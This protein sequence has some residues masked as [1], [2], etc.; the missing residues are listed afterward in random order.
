[1]P[2]AKKEEF[3]DRPPIVGVG[4]IVRAVIIA[5]ILSVGSTMVLASR[6]DERVQ[7]NRDSATMSL[8]SAVE[9]RKA[10]QALLIQKDSEMEKSLLLMQTAQKEVIAIMSGLAKDNASFREE[11][12]R[13]L[14]T[15]DTQMGY[16]VKNIE[17]LK[18]RR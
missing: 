9:L 1:V 13:R 10:D 4:E 3:P 18:Q 5:A 16:L 14:T 2:P 11:A 12:I 7:A 17:E 8:A 6:L 15:L